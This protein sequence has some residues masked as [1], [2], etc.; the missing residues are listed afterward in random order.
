M[1]LDLQVAFV[2]E[3]AVKHYKTKQR[4]RRRLSKRKGVAC[5]MFRGIPYFILL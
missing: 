1:F 4:K 3:K 2:V 5:W